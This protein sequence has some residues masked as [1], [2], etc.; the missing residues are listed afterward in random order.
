MAKI[1]KVLCPFCIFTSKYFDLI[2][3]EDGF[4][5]CPNCNAT[6]SYEELMQLYSL[7]QFNFEIKEKPF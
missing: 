4:Y 1:D 6:F 7:T 5:I 2:L 3:T